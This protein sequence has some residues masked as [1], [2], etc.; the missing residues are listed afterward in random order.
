MLEVW[1]AEM[2]A[3]YLAF[4]TPGK[5]CAIAAT[6]AKS[7]RFPCP[8]NLDTIIDLQYPAPLRQRSG[9]ASMP[10]LRAALAFFGWRR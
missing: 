8:D 5:F 3:Q 6:V 9:L 1:A 2:Q 4:A 10:G 7:F